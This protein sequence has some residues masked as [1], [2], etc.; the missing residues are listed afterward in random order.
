MSVVLG[1]FSFGFRLLWLSVVLGSIG[2]SLACCGHIL[3]WF[4][5]G[6]ASHRLTP[7]GLVTA[8]CCVSGS[9]MVG[10]LG[11]GFLP[12]ADTLPFAIII[13][14]PGFVLLALGI[15]TLCRPG[16]LQEFL[17]GL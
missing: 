14:M 10:L 17:G 1:I 9:I 6:S 16:R 2:L 7:G 13:A 8:L 3:S 12:L 11:L 4:R 15:E 5:R